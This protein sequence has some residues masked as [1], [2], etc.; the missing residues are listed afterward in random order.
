MMK[1]PILP[2]STTLNVRYRDRNTTATK[3]TSVAFLYHN[4]QSIIRPRRSRS[5]A[6][7]SRQIFRWTIC[8]SVCAYVCLR[9]PFGIIGQTG[10]GM[11]QAGFG[12]RSTGRGTFG[13]N[14][15]SAIVT[16]GDF[17]AYVCDSASTA[18]AA[19]CGG[20]SGGLRHCWIRWGP[21]CARKRGG[22]GGFCYTFSQWEMPLRRRRWNV[23]DSYTKNLTTFPFCKRMVGKLDSWA[24][25][26]YIRFQDQRRG[27][28]KLAKK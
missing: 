10:P 2:N 3:A 19:V 23:S 20:A 15:G 13:A 18:G 25:W 12:D 7:Y 4:L 16:N 14:L 8:R 26:R 5:A 6:A 21:R 9:L 24:F 28:D 11:R 27:Y 17:T 1:L 22:F